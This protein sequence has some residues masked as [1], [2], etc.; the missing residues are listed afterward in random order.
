MSCNFMPCYS[1]HHFHVRHFHVL[2]F[3]RPRAARS[4]FS[5][6]V[7]APRCSR[8]KTYT[9]IACREFIVLR[10]SLS[11]SWRDSLVNRLRLWSNSSSNQ[12]SSG[13]RRAR[14]AT[15]RRTR[16]TSIGRSTSKKVFSVFF[17]WRSV[18]SPPS[19]TLNLSSLSLPADRGTSSMTWWAQSVADHDLLSAV[20]W[21]TS[22]KSWSWTSTASVRPSTWST[23]RNLKTSL[24]SVTW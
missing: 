7:M 19:L 10:Q 11:I 16:L 1:V 3:Q 14:C 22:S 2:H 13:W 9:C 5:S 17:R 21:T 12:S 8:C 4:R 6:T 24:S 18:A 20:P 15:F 23:L